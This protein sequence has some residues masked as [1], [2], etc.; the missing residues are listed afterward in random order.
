[1]IGTKSY[2]SN[3]S[4]HIHRSMELWDDLGYSV[5]IPWN[6]VFNTDWQF[7]KPDIWGYENKQ[8]TR[9][10]TEF[11]APGGIVRSVGGMPEI[12]IHDPRYRFNRKEHTY[13]IT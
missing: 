9:P 2:F 6:A 10:D 4:T 3:D 5:D 1:M 13:T 7:A 8:V 11:F 12:N